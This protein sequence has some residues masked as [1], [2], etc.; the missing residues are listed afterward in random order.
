MKSYSDN[1]AYSSIFALAMAE[2]EPEERSV[3]V[4]SQQ[5]YSTPLGPDQANLPR[6]MTEPTLG[7]ASSTDTTAE[8][9][10]SPPP[11]RQRVASAND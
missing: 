6:S 3:Q 5:T 7:G 4:G 10:N 9:V 1:T 8:E 2:N 11:K